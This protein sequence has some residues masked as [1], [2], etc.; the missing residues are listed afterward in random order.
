MSTK[1]L[2]PLPRK[3]EP[4]NAVAEANN[5]PNSVCNSD[6]NTDYDPAYPNRMLLRPQARMSVEAM[7]SRMRAQLSETKDADHGR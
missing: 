5:P 1:R 4:K 7:L 3:R 2:T 6:D